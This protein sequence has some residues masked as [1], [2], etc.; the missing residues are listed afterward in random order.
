[1]SGNSDRAAFSRMF[2][3]S[4]AAFCSVENPTVFLYYLNDFS[5][6]HLQLQQKQ[7]GYLH[8]VH[9]SANY[10]HIHQQQQN[11]K[12]VLFQNV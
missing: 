4:V 8:R 7:N 11:H 5:N 1:M 6:F 2:E 3:L 12:A 9:Q 10:A